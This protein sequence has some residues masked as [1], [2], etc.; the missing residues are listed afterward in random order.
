MHRKIQIPYDHS[1]INV[2]IPEHNIACLYSSYNQT[3][4]PAVKLNKDAKLAGMMKDKK[5]LILLADTTRDIPFQQIIDH[6]FTSLGNAPK[7]VS[8]CLATGTHDG[9]N[10]ENNAILSYAKKSAN[11]HKTPLIKS[12]IHNCHSSPTFYAGTTTRGNDIHVNEILHN[13][14]FILIHA[15][16][17]NHY[18]A[19]YSNPIKYIIP[20]I[21][22]YHT[23]ERNHSLAL[24][25]R[26]TFGH[27]PLHPDVNRRNNPLAQDMWEG[28]QLITESIP[29][30]VLLTITSGRNIVWQKSGP[31][32]DVLP[33]GI[34]TVDKKMGFKVSPAEKLIVSCGGYPN[35]ESLYIAQ[36]ALELTKNALI[37][38]GEILFIAG[39]RNGIGP[40]KSIENFYNPL[41]GPLPLLLEKY[42]KNY[43]MYTHKVFKFAQLI[44]RMHK[45]Y[46][47][48]MLPAQHVSDIH[49]TPVK[50]IQALTDQWIAQT[51][52]CRINI[53][54]DGNKVAVYPQ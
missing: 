48:S 5:V 43:K 12:V 52:H 24:D 20:G 23:I 50:N 44:S 29:V 38:G 35:D 3:E 11:K 25:E 14:D 28:Y 15:D 9:D 30:H 19:G 34:R 53:F 51:P 39:C 4:N 47:Y 41:K 31:L 27:H 18:F 13:I 37:N 45:I 33:D 1:H 2:E 26:S 40:V 46:M 7:A 6:F 36:R 32:T 8:L 17:K 10:K 22:A 21:C 16:M 54:L 42:A 49:L